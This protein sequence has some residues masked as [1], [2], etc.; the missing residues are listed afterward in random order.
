MHVDI[1]A[2]ESRDIS[3]FNT[4]VDVFKQFGSRLLNSTG[5][6]HFNILRDATSG[7][8]SL[9]TPSCHLGDCI[10]PR[11]GGFGIRIVALQAD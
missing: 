10:K 8:Y 2:G 5:S 6:S 9:G 1:L 3:A 11:P 7:R 4:F